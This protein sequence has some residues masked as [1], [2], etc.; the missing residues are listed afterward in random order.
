MTI[1]G[2]DLS[3]Y[4]DG[5]N[6]QVIDDPF[7]I[8][9]CTQGTYY[10]D[11]DYPVWREQAAASHKIFIPYH[12]IS[13]ED[14]DAQAKHIADKIG[15]KSLPLMIDFEPAGTYR[16]TLQQLLALAD[17]CH[18]AGLRVALAYLPRWYWEQI[19][20]PSLSQL[21]SRGIALVS[22]AYPGGSGYPGDGAAGWEPYGGMAPLIYQF[23]NAAPVQGRGVDRNAYRGSRAELAADLNPSGDNVG[24]FTMSDG[25]QDDYQDVAGALQKHIPAGMVID[26]ALAAGYAMV[27]S[28]V[29]AE[30]AGNIET[31]LAEIVQL[32]KA[33][34]PAPTPAPAP[35]VDVTE[36]AAALVT[37]LAAAL[38]PHISGGVDVQ[39]LAQAAAEPVA[40]AVVM[41]LGADIAAAPAPAAS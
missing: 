19:G 22:S 17:A 39:A 24:T 16:P 25:W 31:T 21:D 41:E 36:L 23:T 28:F 7:V 9:K 30:R 4:Q 15:D 14:P 18:R 3:S 10:T 26:E 35:V 33:Q 13:P 38:Q 29:A 11:V 37:P 12:F 20:S 8:C 1:F 32:L 2:D 27:R 6:V 34:A 5:I 40:H